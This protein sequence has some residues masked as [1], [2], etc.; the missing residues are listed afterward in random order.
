MSINKCNF[1]GE[2]NRFLFMGRRFFYVPL[3]VLLLATTCLVSSCGQGGGGISH[4]TNKL[5]LDT[6]LV[7]SRHHL[8]GDTTKPY[9]DIHVSF[10]YP[11]ESQIANLD[12]LQHFFVSTLFGPAYEDLTP[13][14]AVEAYIKSYVDNYNRDAVIYR[15]T[16]GNSGVPYSL[17]PE[18]NHEGNGDADSD[19]F[20]SYY[21]NISNSIVYNRNELISLQV[22][23]S[24]NKGGAASYQ[25]FRNHVYN[26]RKGSPVPE[27]DLFNAGYDTALRQIIIAS[28]LEQNR[29][30]SIDELE[31]LGFFGIQEILPNK[32]FL[33]NEEGIIYTFNKGEYSAYQLEAPEI[34]I[35]YGA[36]RS[37]LRENSIAS[38]LA[39]LK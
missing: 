31:E 8:E 28:L 24:N 21:E 15:E 14:D 2:Y 10:V 17:L 3:S 25:L 11:I 20:Y 4:A 18:H 34:L 16:T 29:V 32:N 26:L 5:T 39:N 36:I 7:D 27:S 23:Q 38:K 1:A 35:P 13:A 6:I 30:K 37:L 9:C 12:S 19:R 33:L 22:K